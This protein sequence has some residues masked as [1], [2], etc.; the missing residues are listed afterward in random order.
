MATHDLRI[1]GMKY[2][3]MRE[4]EQVPHPK[5]G[6]KNTIFKGWLEP[7]TNSKWR[8]ENIN[9]AFTSLCFHWN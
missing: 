8:W 2:R 7:F 6:A 9:H 4:F 1:L 3:N 5:L